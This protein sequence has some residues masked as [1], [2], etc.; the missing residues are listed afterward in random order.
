MPAACEEI[1]SAVPTLPFGDAAVV[2]ELPCLSVMGAWPRCPGAR[3]PYPSPVSA[4]QN[5]GRRQAY[6]LE[7]GPKTRR[8][9]VCENLMA[10]K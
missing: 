10:V 6:A 5:R 7:E 9:V 8:D 3:W 4:D 2:N 1:C